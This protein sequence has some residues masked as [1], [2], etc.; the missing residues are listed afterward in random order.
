MNPLMIATVEKHRKSPCC[1]SPVLSVMEAEVHASVWYWKEKHM[2]NNVVVSLHKQLQERTFQVQDF[3]G[4]LA[5]GPRNVEAWMTLTN[6]S[7]SVSANWSACLHTLQLFSA[8]EHYKSGQK[9]LLGTASI[10]TSTN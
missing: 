5:Y 9:D 1:M 8:L 10:A 2:R 7:M 6:V 3:L 4:I